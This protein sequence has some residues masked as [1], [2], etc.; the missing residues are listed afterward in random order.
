MSSGERP[1]VVGGR[2]SASFHKILT[3]DSINTS[4]KSDVLK[5]QQKKVSYAFFPNTLAYNL[6]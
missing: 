5:Q 3:I 1:R 4:D 2:I 6:K